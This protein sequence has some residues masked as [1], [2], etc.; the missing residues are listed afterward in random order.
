MTFG[1]GDSIAR[2]SGNNPSYSLSLLAFLGHFPLVYLIRGRGQACPLTQPFSGKMVLEGPTVGFCSITNSRSSLLRE[3]ALPTIS[4]I[5]AGLRIHVRWASGWKSLLLRVDKS[6]EKS[7]WHCTF[8][9]T[10]CS[11]HTGAICPQFSKTV[12][13][14]NIL[15]H[16]AHKNTGTC[17]I[18]CSNFWFRK[19]GH[20]IPIPQQMPDG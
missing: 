11:I 12:S 15:S 7:L 5:K 3:L 20:C 1:D 2:K 18:A 4:P 19:Y 16:F 6:W 17:Q 10:A 9:I 13:I 14:S 8:K